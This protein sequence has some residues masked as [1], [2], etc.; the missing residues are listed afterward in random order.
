MGPYEAYQVGLKKK[1][2]VQFLRNG[3]AIFRRGEAR[4]YWIKASRLAAKHP[5][6]LRPRLQLEPDPA[7]FTKEAAVNRVLLSNQYDLQ[8]ERLRCHRG[9]VNFSFGRVCLLLPPK[10]LNIVIF[11]FNGIVHIHARRLV[12][13]RYVQHSRYVLRNIFLSTCSPGYNE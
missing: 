10:R 7:L 2:L 12:C 6:R 5:K 8:L 4:A 3:I 13:L 11:L 9:K 1:K